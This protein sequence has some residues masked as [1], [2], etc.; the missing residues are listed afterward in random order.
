MALP[1]LEAFLSLSVIVALYFVLQRWS[2]VKRTFRTVLRDLAIVAIT[3]VAATFLLR[4]DAGNHW[5]QRSAA[6]LLNIFS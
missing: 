1:S 2:G 5:L 3:W 4:L 6:W